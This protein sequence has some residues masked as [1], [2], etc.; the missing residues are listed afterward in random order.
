MPPYNSALED[1]KSRLDIVDIVSEYVALKKAG[2]NYKGLC[3]FHTEKTPSFMVSPSKQIFHCFGCGSGG[4]IFT[5]LTR[6]ENLSFNEAAIILAKKAG[7]TLKKSPHDAARAG[8]KETLINLN[9]DALACFQKSHSHSPEAASYLKKRG[10]S[11]EM[12]KSFSIGYA[13][14]R[15]DALFSFLKGKGYTAELIK[16]AGLVHYGSSGNYDTFRHRIMFPIFDLRGEVIAFGGRVLSQ[17]DEPKYL[18]SPE[19]P[20]F[21]KGRVLYGLNLA[22]EFIKKS[23]HAIFTEGYF[24]VIAAHMYGLSSAVA[25]LGTALT[26]EHG[27]LI[28]RFTEDAILVFDGDEAGVRAAKSAA[29]ILLESGLNVKVLPLPRGEDP[30]SFLR[31]NGKE[32]FNALLE[33]P[34]S[35]VEFF[36]MQKADKHLTANEALEVIS[37]VPDSIRQGHYIKLLS[38]G[39]GINEMFVRE[40]LKKIKASQLKGAHRQAP[41]MKPLAKQ[42]PSHE[43]YLLRLLL[44]Y[45]EKAERIFESVL[46]EDLEHPVIRSVFKRMKEGMMDYDVLFSE[47]LDDEKNLITELSFRADFDDAEKALGDCL[48][49]FKKERRQRLLNEIQD[50]VKKAESK[51]D[52]RLLR[53]LQIEQQKLLG[54]KGH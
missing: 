42:G 45:P 7:V 31:K 36:L 46:M 3:P 16:K 14:G 38:E 5:F 43:V 1:I 23:G 8:E 41:G 18:N 37:K 20:V 17:H 12:Q 24:D 2:Q 13:P 52:A 6:H 53:A 26:Q 10:I 47:C 30:D 9:K 40:E 34:V 48:N 32:A 39:I 49:R 54:L 44:N 19:T 15:K 35:V 28:K 33:N 29:G 21:N 51:K 25:P 22:K 4:D 11:V 50:K 27:K